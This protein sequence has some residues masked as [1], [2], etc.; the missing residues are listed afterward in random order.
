MRS[1]FAVLLAAALFAA[2][3]VARAADLVVLDADPAQDVTAFAKVHCTIR[4]G[5]VIYR[6]R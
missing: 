1:R 4:N 5:A 2:G 6:E 3:G